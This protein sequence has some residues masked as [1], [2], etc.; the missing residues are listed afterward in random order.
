MLLARAPRANWPDEETATTRRALPSNRRVDTARAN[1]NKTLQLMLAVAPESHAGPLRG[2]RC[3]SI[4][5]LRGAHLLA[6][7]RAPPIPGKRDHYCDSLFF[8]TSMTRET[9]LFYSTLTAMLRLRRSSRRSRTSTARTSIDRPDQVRQTQPLNSPLITPIFSPGP[10]TG[11]TVPL[12]LDDAIKFALERTSTFSARLPAA[13]D[14]AMRARVRRHPLTSQLAARRNQTRPPTSS[15]YCRRRRRE[16]TRPALQ[17]RPHRW[18]PGAAQLRGQ[19]NNN[20]SEIP[21]TTCLNRLTP[22]AG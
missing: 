20:R 16:S 2:G 15:S 12:T 10:A 22:T 6:P 19:L 13:A 21:S 5:R 11:P 3:W 7:S 1:L 18:R 17:R 4:V 9:P 14:I 8:R